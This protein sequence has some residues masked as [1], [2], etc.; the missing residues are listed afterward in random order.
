[1]NEGQFKKKMQHFLDINNALYKE[2][3]ILK[4]NMTLKEKFDKALDDYII[5]FGEYLD[6][7]TVEDMGTLSIKELYEK[8]KKEKGL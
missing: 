1:M 6:I 7:L 8:F 4:H 5:Q 2:N 3:Q